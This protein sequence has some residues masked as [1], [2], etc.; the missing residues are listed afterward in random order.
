MRFILPFGAAGVA[1]ITSRIAAEKLGEKLGQRFVVENQPGPGGIAAA[2]AV[3]S[4]PP[5][6]YT[7]RPRDQRHLDQRG[8]LQDAAVRPG[9]G[10]RR[11]L[12]HRFLR[13]RASPPTRS[14]EFKTLAGLHQGGAASSPASSMS[15]P[16]MSAAP[17]TLPPSCSNPRPDSTSRSFLIAALRTSS[18]R[19]CATTCSSWSISMRPMKP[20]LARQEDPRHCHVRP[21]ALAISPRRADASPKPAFPATR[22]CR[23]TE[24][25]PARN[26][27]GDHQLLNKAIREIVAIPE[28]KEHYA[29]LGIEAKASSPRG[30][31]TRL[32][33]D[34]SQMGGRDRAC[35]HCEAVANSGR[36]SGWLCSPFAIRALAFAKHHLCGSRKITT[37]VSSELHRLDG[38]RVDFDEP[39]RIHQTVD[40]EKR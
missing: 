16:S 4:Q 12:D 21:A 28:V 15:A 38:D 3:L 6:G 18:S 11:H 35:R 34:I 33:A 25:L 30:V 39:A 5:D 32:Q 24:Y 8:D 26:A 2:R 40:E 1:D 27:R 10:F 17:R 23:G 7:H 29:D 36:G 22:S 14:S 20:T 37:K 19:C 31:E 13:S 9:Q